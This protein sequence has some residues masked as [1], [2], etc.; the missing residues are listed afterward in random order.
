MPTY[1]TL[2]RVVLL[3][4]RA[5]HAGALRVGFSFNSRSPLVPLQDFGAVGGQ[6]NVTLD[7]TPSECMSISS[8]GSS[9][10]SGSQ[11][12][13]L[14]NATD[15]LLALDLVYLAV[16]SRSQWNNLTLRISGAVLGEDTCAQAAIG[17][18]S[19]SLANWRVA[20][21]ADAE[22]VARF[23]LSGAT[24]NATV[25]SVVEMPS[26]LAGPSLRFSL[27]FALPQRYDLYTLSL[28]NCMGANVR[29]VGEASFVGGK[30]ER[31][32]TAEYDLLI[33]RVGFL[34]FTLAAAAAIIGFSCYHRATALPLHFC[35]GGVL[36][37]RAATGIFGL[38]PVLLDSQNIIT[39][40]SGATPST[41][42]E[43]DAYSSG[44][45]THAEAAHAHDD[46]V[47]DVVGLYGRP[48]PP[49]STPAPGLVGASGAADQNV[50]AVHLS[51]SGPDT[52]GWST[53]RTCIV[54]SAAT[55]QLAALYFLVIL[56]AISAGRHFL[57]AELPGRESDAVVTALALY[58]VFGISQDLC[59]TEVF[60]GIVILSFQV[61]KILLVFAVLLFLNTLT[62]HLR[63]NTGHVWA[64][65][66]VDLLHLTVYRELRVR[67]LLVYLILPIVFMFLEVVL[68]WRSTWFKL[69]WREG[70]EIYI[71]LAVATRLLP[72]PTNYHVFFATLR[73][74]PGAAV[75]S[76]A[77]AMFFRWLLGSTVDAVRADAAVAA[78]AAAA[79]QQEQPRPHQ[80]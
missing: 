7:I 3:S 22:G 33:V 23:G 21:E 28:F 80:Q 46:V 54:G 59:E 68:D 8:S 19:L 39:P 17:W 72:T 34:V 65:L 38:I 30:G 48:Y 26:P 1:C 45:Y 58:L 60:C 62:D 36:L 77:Y 71:I 51:V 29:A 44:S 12:Q 43:D 40:A 63:R 41:Q 18:S 20:A 2:V 13:T 24:P 53:L 9:G 16:F 75:A 15:C 61:V 4:F 73:P 32:S 42:L 66:R 6:V 67:V 78:E 14:G 11:G 35:I 27:R 64:Q 74:R 79:A 10:G 69:L 25:D 5:A 49:S 37:L 55:S 56:L 52:P 50:A 31:L 70:L 57:S 76:G 47:T